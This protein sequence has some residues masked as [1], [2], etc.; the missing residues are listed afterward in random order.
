VNID[1]ASVV[2]REEQVL[3]SLVAS[4]DL[5]ELVR[6]YPVRETAAL[7]DV[8]HR[9]GFQGRETYEAAVRKLLR[10]DRE[11]LS[12]ARTLFGSLSSDLGS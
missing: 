11:A 2:E 3:H 5:D 8:A 10:D 9:L 7:G 1:V 6:R 12:H 4:D